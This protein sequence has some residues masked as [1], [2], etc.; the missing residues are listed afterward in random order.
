MPGS[1]VLLNGFLRAE[2]HNYNPKKPFGCFFFFI[3][4]SL[5]ASMDMKISDLDL[6]CL[7]QVV[8]DFTR[9]SLLIVDQFC[10]R[11]SGRF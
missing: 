2:T 5:F 10:Q 8:N 4:L 7:Q 11:F 1:F 9:I 3:R 6:K